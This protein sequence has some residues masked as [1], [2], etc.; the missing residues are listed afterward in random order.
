MSLIRRQPAR[1]SRSAALRSRVRSAAVVK[2]APASYSNSLT[3]ARQP[4]SRGEFQRGKPAPQS[5]FQIINTALSLIARRPP[6]CAAA[7]RSRGRRGRGLRSVRCAA[8]AIPASFT[9]SGCRSSKSLNHR[10]RQ[11]AGRKLAPTMSST[12]VTTGLERRVRQ[13]HIGGA[14]RRRF[15]GSGSG[16]GTTSSPGLKVNSRPRWSPRRAVAAARSTGNSGRHW[17]RSPGGVHAAW[18]RHRSSGHMWCRYG[19]NSSPP[20]TACGRIELAGV[21][22][23][24]EQFGKAEKALP[25]VQP[26]RQH[27]GRQ[28][29]R[30]DGHR[31]GNLTATRT[32]WPPRGERGLKAT[33][34]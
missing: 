14:W 21:V 15:A 2:P 8:I 19:S 22:I 29:F 32:T 25:V 20:G 26:P 5:A 17:S 31:G 9:A 28:H 33:A 6:R 18:S 13:I 7:A 27:V 30:D 34:G 3:E 11:A 1:T 23:M 24:L 12:S 10:Q 4:G 16:A